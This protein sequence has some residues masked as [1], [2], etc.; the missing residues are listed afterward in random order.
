MKN[1]M[2]RHIHSRCY[3]YFIV[4][5]SRYC[6]LCL[7]QELYGVRSDLG[8]LFK[9]LGRLEDAKVNADCNLPFQE[10]LVIMCTPVRDGIKHILQ[11]DKKC[12]HHAHFLK[13]GVE[14]ILLKCENNRTKV[15]E[16]FIS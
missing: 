4:C 3:I 15:G 9:A 2:S 6:V 10:H 8:N 1:E 12:S 13:G 11:I 16:V 5:L 14:Y 7:L